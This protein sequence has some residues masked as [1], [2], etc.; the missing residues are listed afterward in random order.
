MR[1]DFETRWTAND[2]ENAYYQWLVTNHISY[3]NNYSVLLR[4]LYDTPFRVMVLMDENRVGDGLDMRNRFV[5]QNGFGQ[6]ERDILRQ[7]R[8]CSVLEVMIGLAQ[9]FDEE[10]SAQHSNEDPIGGL[11]MSM[12]ASLG[13][14]GYDDQHFDRYGFNQIILNLLNRT[15]SPDGLGSLFYIPGITVDMRQIEIWRQMMMYYEGGN[16]IWANS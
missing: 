11:V 9:R 8:P 13:L 3:W 5:Y 12:I 4:S 1:T 2:L 14:Q 10:Y 7:S 16:K 6:L 15:Y